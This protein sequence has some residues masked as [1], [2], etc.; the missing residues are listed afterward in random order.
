MIGCVEQGCIRIRMLFELPF[1]VREFV[2][3]HV[4]KLLEGGTL[5]SNEFR[6]SP[7]NTYLYRYLCLVCN[8]RVGVFHPSVDVGFSQLDFPCFFFLSHLADFSRAARDSRTMVPARPFSESI[9]KW[10]FTIRIK[11]SIRPTQIPPTQATG[12]L[13]SIPSLMTMIW[14]R[15]R[16]RSLQIEPVAPALDLLPQ[17]R[18]QPEQNKKEQKRRDSIMK[19]TD[20]RIGKRARNPSKRMV[21]SWVNSV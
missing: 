6:M 18:L 13:H 2:T 1:V 16:S 12:K 4:A 8:D 10:I 19:T 11:R 14:L 5:K 15:E 7:Y 17:W 9:M 20:W 3:D 21:T